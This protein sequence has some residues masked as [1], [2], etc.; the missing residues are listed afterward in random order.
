MDNRFDFY[1]IKKNIINHFNKINLEVQFSSSDNY[2]NMV[3]FRAVD[4]NKKEVIPEQIKNINEIDNKKDLDDYLRQ[5]ELF[6][7]LR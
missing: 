3:K 1:E 4:N 6:Y 5:L 7:N 2:Q